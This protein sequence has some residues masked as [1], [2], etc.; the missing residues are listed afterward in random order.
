MKKLTV[1]LF[2]AVMTVL[3]IGSIETTFADHLEGDGN[4]LLAAM[5][6]ANIAVALPD[7]KYQIHLQ[8][9]IRD[10]DGYLIQVSESTSAAF[11][12]HK[13]TDQVFDTLMGKVKPVTIDGI[14]Y[15]KVTFT[16]IPDLQ[17]RSMGLYP[18]WS[19]EGKFNVEFDEESARQM[20]EEKN[21]H[22]IFKIHYCKDFGEGHDFQCIPIFQSLLPMVTVEPSDEI[23]LQWT[24][25]RNNDID[26]TP[27]IPPKCNV[28]GERLDD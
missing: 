11:V 3:L 13:L 17:Q 1:L 14:E 20:F 2:G 19:E 4:S 16:F 9:V 12:P 15:D 26:A 23:T 22:A 25:L 18:I 24:V 6:K 5:Q 21:N 8:T 7:S 28:Y 10:E 27:C